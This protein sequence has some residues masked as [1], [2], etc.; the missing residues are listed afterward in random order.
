MATDADFLALLQTE[1][2]DDATRLVYADWLDERGDAESTAKAE[3]LRKTVELFAPTKSKRQQRALRKRLQQLAAR[4]DTEWLAV[5]SRLAIENC[6]NKPPRP[7][8]R[9]LRFDFLCDRK[10][11]DLRAT[12]GRAVRFCDACRH[13]VHYCGTITEA[14][15]H[16]WEG[17][18]VAV[19]LGVNRVAGD[20]APPRLLVGRI[21][22]DHFEREDQ[23]MEPDPV[24][25]KR[26]R[27]KRGAGRDDEEA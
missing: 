2:A 23:R 9:L 17:H 21:T 1:P 5:V 7:G 16:A 6:H 11:E 15:R 12:D 26:E 13:N 14:R 25:A 18:C 24:S 3:F 4:L 22:P 19:D 10:W 20:L 27:R 8:S